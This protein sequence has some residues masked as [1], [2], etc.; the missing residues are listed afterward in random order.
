MVTS[1]DAFTGENFRCGGF[2]D[3]ADRYRR[4]EEFITVAREFWDS[5]APRSTSTFRPMR[6]TGSSW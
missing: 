6:A 4:A 1:S 5:W 2:L 3:H